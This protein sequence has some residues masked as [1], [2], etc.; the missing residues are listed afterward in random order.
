MKITKKSN[1]LIL[2]HYYKRT[3]SGG[4]PPQEIRDYFLPS[5]STIAYI[6]H[7]FPYADD[8]R[9]SLTIYKDGKLV[10]QIFTPQV[11]G[12]EWFYYVVDIFITWYFYLH[13]P[14]TF[15]LCVALDNLNTFSVIPLKKFGRIKKL[16]FYTI[17]YTPTRFLNKILNNIYHSLDRIACYNADKI[18]IL[19][20]VMISSRRKNGVEMKKS[21]PSI[22]TP[23]GANLERIQ[24]LPVEKINRHQLI[25]VG[26]LLEKQGVQLL[27]QTLP[28]VVRKI[29][30]V[31]LIIIGKGDYELA[32]KQLVKSN[33]L[34]NHVTFR[35]FV[36]KHQEV[37]K[38]LCKSAI[39]IATYVP[40]PDSYTYFTD[41]GKP[42]LYLGCGL[43]VIITD[44]PASARVIDKQRAGICISY[45]KKSLENALLK[46]LK[47]DELYKKY[48]ENA[49]ILSKRYNTNTIIKNAVNKT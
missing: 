33:S 19:S 47:S 46:L 9:S 24:V 49:L 28:D 39:G 10:K 6:E 36:E 42:K 17:D 1:I 23:M 15:D 7:P 22:I 27:L 14:I 41:P 20:P 38:L 37:E 3:I 32:L 13:L 26:A 40:S 45:T 48:R 35:G 25:F 12:S 16:V 34:S 29:K 2:S 43:P 11:K 31:H 8:H 18:W 4:G 5:V 21:A 44:V 30:D